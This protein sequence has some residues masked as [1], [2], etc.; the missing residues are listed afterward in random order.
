V[1]KHARPLLLIA[2]D[3]APGGAEFIVAGQKAGQKWFHGSVGVG[4]IGHLGMEVLKTNVKG[5]ASVHVPSNGN[6]QVVTSLVGGEIQMALVPPGVAHADGEGGKASRHRPHRRPQR[7][8]PRS[9]APSRCGRARLQPRGVDR[10]CGAARITKA[11]LFSG[12][13]CFGSVR[14]DHA[15][16]LT[17][18]KL[19][20]RLRGGIAV[21][22]GRQGRVEYR[23]PSCCGRQPLSDRSLTLGKL[24]PNSTRR[25]TTGVCGSRITSA[26]TIAFE[27]D[28]SRARVLIQGIYYGGRDYGACARRRHRLGRVA[29][30]GQSVSER[31]HACVE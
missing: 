27:I 4:S 26:A 9:A 16:E 7:A 17:A 1:R 31:Y 28:E 25:R 23:Q 29:W 13:V 8:R 21:G 19:T 6:P 24:G 11:A 20:S 14:V 5:L 18:E 3:S 10:A 30:P 22:H 15:G 12:E 2:P